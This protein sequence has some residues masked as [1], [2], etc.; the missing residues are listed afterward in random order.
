MFNNKQPIRHAYYKEY[1]ELQKLCLT[2]LQQHKHYIGSNAEKIHG[3]IFDGAWLWEEYIDTLIHEDF[4]HP[5][6]KGGSG[7]QRLFSTQMG[8]KI[9]LVYPDFIGRN[10]KYRII[11]D[12]KYKPIQNIGNRDYLQVLAYMYRFDAK[13]GYY[14]FL[15]QTGKSNEVLFLNQGITYEKNV[16]M[17]E[18]IKI[19]KVGLTIPKETIDYKEFVEKMKISEQEFLENKVYIKSELL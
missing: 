19:I 18:D 1:R 11:G 5:K 16:Q 14:F 10:Q 6:N 8:A 2:I 3:I 15:N 13:T 12:A 9:G 4:Y 7:A 17:R